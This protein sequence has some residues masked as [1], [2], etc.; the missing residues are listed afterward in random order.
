MVNIRCETL[1]PATRAQATAAYSALSASLAGETVVIL[2]GDAE[3]NAELY[4]LRRKLLSE[5]SKEGL[6]ELGLRMMQKIEGFDAAGASSDE[7]IA[8]RAKSLGMACLLAGG[9]KRCLSLELSSIAE[10]FEAAAEVRRRG[11]ATQRLREMQLCGLEAKGSNLLYTLGGADKYYYRWWG[12]DDDQRQRWRK[13]ILKAAAAK[14]AAGG[15]AGGGSAVGAVH[16][17]AATAASHITHVTKRDAI[18][19]LLVAHVKQT[20]PAFQYEDW[21][22]AV[23]A[24]V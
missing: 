15:R 17:P 9:E 2:S 14:G 3:E 6:T 24:S 12:V 22:A 16:L 18:F 8:S 7:A 4:A 10:I 21:I 11:L 13:E 20:N 5:I 19:D 1:L 23:R